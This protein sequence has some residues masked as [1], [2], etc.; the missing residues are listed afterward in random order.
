MKPKF[1]LFPSVTSMVLLFS[2]PAFADDTPV[3]GNLNYTGW[4]KFAE[5]IDMGAN[6]ETSFNWL[7]SKTTGFDI[8][9]A[10]GVFLWRDTIITSPASSKNKMQLD[11][12]NALSLYKST[13]FAG[14]VLAPEAGKITF[15]AG[16]GSATGSGIYFG[17]STSAT[18][19][20]A[21]DGSAIFPGQVAFQNGLQLTN[22]ALSISSATAA[23]SSSGAV[24][25]AGGISVGLDSYFNGVRIGKGGGNVESN[26]VVGADALKDNTTGSLNLAVGGGALG[27][28]INGWANTACGPATLAFNTNGVYNA[29]FGAFS[30]YNNR[31]SYNM[32]VGANALYAN[33]TGGLNSAIGFNALAQNT[34]GQ[35]NAG[36][37]AFSLAENTNGSWNIAIG[38]SALS[39]NVMGSYN[40]ALGDNSLA[41]NVSGYENVSIGSSAGRYRQ[42]TGSTS[43]VNPSRSV[44]IGKNSRGYEN[45]EENSI[46][47]GANSVGEGTNTTVIGNSSTI[48]AHLYGQVVTTDATASNSSTTG[49]LIV[50][51]GIGVAKDSYVNGVKIGR[52]AGNMDSNT[53]LGADAMSLN[54]GGC[55][56]TAVGA[57]ALYSN[58][59]SYNTAIGFTSLWH[60]TTGTGNTASGHDSLSSNTEGCSNSATGAGSLRSNTTGWFNTA[61]GTSSSSSNTTGSH[62]TTSGYNSLFN[63]TTG[64][65][66]TAFGSVAGYSTTTGSSNIF[67]GYAAG[68]FQEDGTTAL[69][70]N[71]SI[72]IGAN[73]QG[74][75]NSDNN[76]IVIGTGAKGLGANTTVI[77][78]SNTIKTKLY[79]TT[80]VSALSAP[81]GSSPLVVL[82]NGEV[83]IAG[84]LVVSGSPVLSQGTTNSFL[85]SQGYFTQSGLAA[86]LVTAAPPVSS[87]AWTNAFIPRGN[88]AQG[89]GQTSGGLFALGY[90]S[91][92]NGANAIA[93]GVNADSSGASSTAVGPLSTASGSTSFAFGF[94]CTASGEDSTASGNNATASG[95]GSTASGVYSIASGSRSIASG[96]LAKSTG[97][98]AIASGQGAIA[99]GYN[100][101][102]SGASSITNGECSISGGFNTVTNSYG[103]TALGLFNTSSAGNLYSQ[104]PLDKLFSVGNGSSETSRTNAISVLK[105]GQTTL[106]NKEWKANV[107]PTSSNSNGEALVVEGNT[108]LQGDTQVLGNT[109]L[110]GKVTIAQPQGD[111]S[112]GIYGN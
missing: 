95:Q 12:A 46:V 86:A 23:S 99:N 7:G 52:G 107:A 103:E 78:T 87:V 84:S 89:A 105:N 31:G 108:R 17:G 40:V 58:T 48:K 39:S 79:G 57:R 36:I 82:N 14:I 53:V 1:P 28:N 5:G 27:R 101:V 25:V 59:S 43:L 72:Y 24:T 81:A 37:G 71:N 38:S 96:Q 8:V 11:G 10:Q 76:S 49:A 74:K 77:G 61:S 19:S 111:I 56:N 63:N 98:Y 45:A 35:H 47:I 9:E 90:N 91:K 112:M 73:S 3:A 50:S 44:Y 42:A 80:E 64:H 32:A 70:S 4:G 13:G 41:M 102:A 55:W 97:F 34:E 16:T 18:L 100:S 54:T 15:P 85:Q 104:Q 83:Q 93:L 92:A 20:A 26:T 60:N 22:G 65:Y 29:A 33:T 69:T 75:N 66:N 21:S 67:L 6:S 88:V 109:Q 110:M 30:L 2:L 51:G 68:K 106:T 94:Y 62:N